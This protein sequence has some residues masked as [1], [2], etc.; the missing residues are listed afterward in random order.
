MFSSYLVKHNGCFWTVKKEWFM[1][2]SLE[3]METFQPLVGTLN[4]RIHYQMSNINILRI[5][6]ILLI[7]LQRILVIFI[8]IHSNS[9][10]LVDIS[11]LS[12]LLSFL[13]S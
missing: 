8:L 5:K 4:N 2:V 11:Q 10:L 1:I 12:R 3:L 6:V 7:L 13:F 9:Q